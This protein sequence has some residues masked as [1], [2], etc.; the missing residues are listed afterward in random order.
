MD[1][2]IKEAQE[3]FRW[4][5]SLLATSC[6]IS[7][8]SVG[9]FDLECFPNYTTVSVIDKHGIKYATS[10]QSDFV[11]RVTKLFN[12]DTIY[13]GFN[14]FFFD[15]NLLNSISGTPLDNYRL[16]QRLIANSEKPA[17]L[18]FGSIRTLDLMGLRSP[19]EMMGLKGIGAKENPYRIQELP[20][21]FTKELTQ[22][23]R[24]FTLMYNFNDCIITHQLLL[25][26]L[27]D[28][29]LRVHLMRKYR[30]REDSES[31]CRFCSAKGASV[32][33]QILKHLYELE[34]TKVLKLVDL[35]PKVEFKKASE[36]IPDV[37]FETENLNDYK[38]LIANTSINPFDFKEKLKMSVKIGGLDYE[39]GSGGVH[40]AVKGFHK[41]S[42]TTTI[43]DFDVTS[44]YPSLILAYSI[45]PR[46]LSETFLDVYSQIVDDRK[47][48]KSDKDKFTADALKL[49]INSTFGKFNNI[50]WDDSGDVEYSSF[51]YDWTACLSITLYGQFFLLK[52]AEM[53]TLEGI[54]VIS[55]NT[56]GITLKYNND[57]RDDVLRIVNRWQLETNMCLEEHQYKLINII[58]VNNYISV[59]TDDEMKAKGKF[60]VG[61]GN[62]PAIVVEACQSYVTTG[63]SVD[64]YINSS[65]EIDKFVSIVNIKEPFTATYDGKSQGHIVRYYH[66]FSRTPLLKVDDKRIIAVPD[67]TSVTIVTTR[68]DKLPSD[69]DRGR[70]I[71]LAE[72]LLGISKQLEL[73]F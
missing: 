64:E 25:K 49:V 22:E 8:Y 17:Y 38:A 70:Y 27:Q 59:D 3:Y 29:E 12:Q 24:K 61:S 71:K 60:V 58:D 34:G 11:S 4:E 39:V 18:L 26:K 32:A 66:S 44:Y 54:L 56:D 52:L 10:T 62:M 30:M 63:K 42:S 28:I 31:F 65:T 46:H 1:Q 16:G 41:S 67:A 73:N 43:S 55:A 51:L 68:L 20:Y 5:E 14:N 7:G 50:A 37:K 47:R 9:V 53:L 57:R 69:L 23:E 45:K 19:K 15:N 35:Y 21:H 40:A 33:E 36:F 2:L 72:D 48:A 6:K 13:V